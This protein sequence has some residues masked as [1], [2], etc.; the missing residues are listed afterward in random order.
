MVVVKAKIGITTG[1]LLI[2]IH[3]GVPTLASYLSRWV[4]SSVVVRGSTLIFGEQ[5]SM[6]CVVKINWTTPCMVYANDDG[7]E[8]DPPAS[9][10]SGHVQITFETCANLQ[11]FLTK[12]TT[13]YIGKQT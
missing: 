8:L 9:P 1:A 2:Q 4:G 13:L 6:K 11:S 7:V 12:I 3:Q 10:N 5:V